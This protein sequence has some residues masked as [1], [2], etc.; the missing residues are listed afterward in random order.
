M[1]STSWLVGGSAFPRNDTEKC[2][3]AKTTRDSIH[4]EVTRNLVSVR[5]KP[6]GLF[7]IRHSVKFVS[8]HSETWFQNSTLGDPLRNTTSA[9]SLS[10]E[11]SKDVEES[12][13]Q[14]SSESGQRQKVPPCEHRPN[15]ASSDIKTWLQSR[16]HATLSQAAAGDS[17]VLL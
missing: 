12:S 17:P 7:V 13:L 16:N 8:E 11:M 6:L 4:I 1:V 2:L 9:T 3:E 14:C 15:H 10:G 5:L